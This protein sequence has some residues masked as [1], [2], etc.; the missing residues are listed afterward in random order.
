MDEKKWEWLREGLSLQTGSVSCVFKNL[1]TGEMF[2]Y[3]PEA[4][5]PSASTI[6]IFL[7]SYIYQLIEDGR[8]KAEDPVSFDPKDLADSSGVLYYLRDVKALSV[9]DLIE[10]MIII[11]DNSATNILLS[12]VGMENMQK[13]LKNTL[14]L[15]NTKFQRYMMDF[16]AAEKGFQNYTTAL[17]TAVMLEKIY[18][19]EMVSKNACSEMMRTLK[20]QQF[21]DLIGGNLDDL[22]PEHNIASKSGGLSG[23]VHDTAVVDYGKE[24]FVL[25]M[26]GSE[27]NVAAYAQFIRESARRIYLQVQE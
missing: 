10:L 25:C 9:R 12:L 11:S 27:T 23:V 18:R 1:V 24:P 22:V 6:K 4:V 13:Y 14:G 19:G 16:E 17:D 3:R 7:M 20:N 2:T 15:E 8:M 26:F 5:H 21:Q